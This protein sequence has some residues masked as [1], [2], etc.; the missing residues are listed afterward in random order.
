MMSFNIEE[1]I[2]SSDQIFFDYDSGWA[3]DEDEDD[4]F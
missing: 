2:H 3:N 1:D 4:E